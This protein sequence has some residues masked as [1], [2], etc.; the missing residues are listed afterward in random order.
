M[1]FLSLLQD[2][3][4]LAAM[5]LLT[6]V[7]AW[8][9]VTTITGSDHGQLIDMIALITFAVLY[10]AFNAVFALRI[11]MKVSTSYALQII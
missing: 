5:I 10:L 11:W 8:H 1:F 7:C 4:V 6:S 9:G 2:K 3:Y